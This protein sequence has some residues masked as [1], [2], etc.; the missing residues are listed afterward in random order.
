[1]NWQ[2]VVTMM[3]TVATRQHGR[4]RSPGSK[5]IS[6]QIAREFA[7]NALDT[8]GKTMVIMGAGINHWF[9]SDMTYRSIINNLMLCGCEGVSGGGWAHYSAKKITA[10]RRLEYDCLCQ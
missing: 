4:R 8:G 10:T 7:Q 1:M 3:S 9:N 6:R 5:L 2:R